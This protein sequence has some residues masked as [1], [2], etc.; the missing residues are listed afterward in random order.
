MEIRKKIVIIIPKLYVGGGAETVVLQLEKILNKHYDIIF[1]TFHNGGIIRD[2]LICLNQSEN[3]FFEFLQIIPNAWRLKKICKKY[4]IDTIIAHL[5]RSNTV[6]IISKVM[7]GTRTK[8]LLVTHSANPKILKK[9]GWWMNILWRNAD[10]NI[11]VSRGVKQAID[12]IGVK[13]TCVIYNPFDFNKIKQKTNEN[14]EKQD[15]C[16]F[17][18]NDHVFINI[19]RL[20][21]AKGQKYLISAFAKFNSKY[22]NTKLIILGEGELRS[23]LEKQILDL[24]MQD[25]I[26][27]IG[28][29]QNVFPYLRKSSCFILSSLWEGLPTVL[30]EAISTGLPVIATDC[31]AGPRE[32]LTPQ[33]NLND[34]LEY[35]QKCDMGMLITPLDKNK[36]KFEVDLIDSMEKNMQGRFAKKSSDK[37]LDRFTSEK[38]LKKWQQII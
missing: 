26:F 22:S 18:G 5:P 33:N 36:M 2:N 27:L 16:L 4:N 31:V 7:F 9:H 12:N 15:E 20:I 25:K 13:N 8:N 10:M 24:N 28:N 11:A 23:I 34:E 17:F 29:K 38:I 32:I 30:I 19:G 14:V 35:P 6:T 37:L 1:F 21:E 3:L